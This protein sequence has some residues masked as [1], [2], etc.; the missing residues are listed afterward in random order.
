MSGFWGRR[1]R[2]VGKVDGSAERPFLQQQRTAVLANGER[3]GRT[4]ALEAGVLG[5]G[6]LLRMGGQR[7]G[8]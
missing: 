4:R 7:D 5:Q 8:R 6:G 1:R 3:A 2:S